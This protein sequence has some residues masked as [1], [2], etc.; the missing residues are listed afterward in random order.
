MKD[1]KTIGEDL[2][3]KLFVGIDLAKQGAGQDVMSLIRHLA[4]GSIEVLASYIIGT[5][6]IIIIDGLYDIP[7]LDRTKYNKH[8]K[9]K[10]QPNRGPV[11]R[12]SW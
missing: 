1:T 4:D 2:H 5:K 6:P 7:A 12:N 3:R 11:S 10:P 9:R 8:P